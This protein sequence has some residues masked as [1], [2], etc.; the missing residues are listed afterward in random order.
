LLFFVDHDFSV[1]VDRD[2]LEQAALQKKITALSDQLFMNI[3]Y[4]NLCSLLAIF[5]C[6]LGLSMPFA[7]RAFGRLA[8]Y[9]VVPSASESI[10]R[11]L[12]FVIAIEAFTTFLR[13]LSRIR[14]LFGKV[15]QAHQQ[16]LAS[17]G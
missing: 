6:L 11:W 17:H 14:Y 15:R 5:A 8:A 2:S 13:L 3:H 7:D 10:G 16:K 9:P 12:L 4:F 1:V